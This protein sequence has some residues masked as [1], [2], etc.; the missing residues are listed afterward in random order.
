MTALAR[1][2][3]FALKQHVKVS[4]HQGIGNPEDVW[5]WQPNVPMHQIKF[6][7]TTASQRTRTNTQGI[8]DVGEYY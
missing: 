7:E 3:P 2:I 8:A 6:D 5:N 1:K 4:E